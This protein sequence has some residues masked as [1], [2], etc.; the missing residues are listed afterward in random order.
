MATKIKSKFKIGVALLCTLMML[1][2]IIPTDI[3]GGWEVDA[4][5][6][7]I[8][9]NKSKYSND[10]GWGDA[11]GIR[12]YAEFSDETHI[13]PAGTDMSVVTGYTD[14]IYSYT[15]TSQPSNFTLIYIDGS[16]GGSDKNY[17]EG[18]Q[19]EGWPK[20]GQKWRQTQPVS[21]SA[22]DNNKCYYINGHS[23]E[24]KTLTSD[25]NFTPPT[26]SIAGST[27]GFVDM[28][29]SL[30]SM[31]Y[32]F[33]GNSKTETEK[34]NYTPGSVITVGDDYADYTTIN[35]Y[36]GN[37]LVK[38]IDLTSTADES[39]TTYRSDSTN[40]L[41]YGATVKK[42]DNSVL[43]SYWGAPRP[44]E[45]TITNLDLYFSKTAFPEGATLT[46]TTPLA[47][48]GDIASVARGNARW[49]VNV[50]SGKSNDITSVDNG[51]YIYNFYWDNPSSENNLLVVNDLIATVSG[52]Y[53]QAEAYE[54]YFDA[55]LSKLSYNGD[56]SIKSNSSMPRSGETIYAY[57]YKDD[58]NKYENGKFLKLEKAEYSNGINTWK[59]VY[60]LTLPETFDPAQYPHIIF[61][62]STSTSG[63]SKDAEWPNSSN[64]LSAQTV[65]LQLPAK[66]SPNNCFYADTSDQAI[67]NN[68][69]RNGYWGPVYTVRDAESGKSTDVVP[70]AESAFNKASGT[71]YVNSTFY[72]YYSDYELN[73][74]DRINYDDVGNN[75]PVN[76]RRYSTFRQFAQALS[77]Y[78]EKN[79]KDGKDTLKKNA[80]YTGHF[81][82]NAIDDSNKNYGAPFSDIAGALSLYGWGT[83]YNKTFQSNNNS[84]QSIDDVSSTVGAFT[85]SGKKYRYATQNILASDLSEDSRLPYM[86]GTTDK[87]SGDE[88]YV[89][90]PYFNKAFIEGENCKNTVLG[91]IY[92]NVAFPFTKVDRDDNGVYY[93]SFDSAATTVHMQKNDKTV[94]ST[95]QY[96]YYLSQ[97]SQKT[98]TDRQGKTTEASRSSE[99]TESDTTAANGDRGDDW[100]KNVDASGHVTNADGVSNVYGFFPLNNQ[101]AS[102]NANNYNYGFGTKLEFDF[103]LT[104]D[105]NVVGIDKNERT[106]TTN[107]PITFNFSGDDDVWV[108]ID[109][110][111]VLDIGGDHGRTSG[112]INFSSTQA[113][114]YSYSFKNDNNSF[115]VT[116]NKIP[117][118]SVFVSEVKN[119]ANNPTGGYSNIP[120]NESDPKITSPTV[121]SLLS[122]LGTTKEKFF[123]G[124][125]KLT[126]FYMERG[127]WESNLKL[128]FNFPDSDTLEI[129]KKVDTTNL[130]PLFNGFFDDQSIFNYTVKNLATHYG[131][132][133]AIGGVHTYDDVIFA[134]NF[135][136]T[137]SAS[138][139][140]NTFEKVDY[141]GR[142]NVAHYWAKDDN[143]SGSTWQ[144]YTQKRLGTFTIDNGKE[145]ADYMD[146]MSAL[147]FDVYSGYDLTEKNM[148]IKLTD[149]NGYTLSGYITTEDTKHNKNNWNTVTV[150][151]STLS[152]DG[153]FS[154]QNL[155]SISFAYDYQ[156]DIWLD[157][158]VFTS[159]T[160]V[161][162]SGVGF[163]TNQADIP[164]YRSATSGNL[165]LVKGAVYSSNQKEGNQLVQD[166]GVV[167]LENGEVV[168]FN[169]Q[170]RRGSYVS[171]Q[172]N[173]TEKQNKLFT[174]TWTMYEDGVAVTSYT[175]GSTVINPDARAV[176]NPNQSGSGFDDGRI[177]VYTPEN[178]NT[179]YTQSEKP[180][181]EPAIV[182]RSYSN[183]DDDYVGSQLKL[184]NTN[185]INLG[186]ISF[187]K[188]KSDN[189]TENLTGKYSF[190]V[191]FRNIGGVGLKKAGQETVTSELYTLS[192]GDT[193]TITGIPVG[194]QYTIYEI[195]PDDGSY[196]E[197]VK[198]G[199]TDL[200]GDIFETTVSYD[201][202]KNG[203]ID[204]TESANKHKA[205]AYPALIEAANDYA[206]T[207]ANVKKA[208]IS[209]NMKKTWFVP[210]GTTVS[211]T[212]YFSLVRRAA[213]STSEADWTPVATY[214]K[215]SLTSYDFK[216][217][218]TEWTKEFTNLDEYT[219]DNQ[220][221]YVYKIVEYSYDSESK[222]YT[223]LEDGDKFNTFNTSYTV[224]YGNENTNGINTDKGTLNVTNTYTPPSP[225][226][227]PET[228][229]N[230][231]PFNYVLFGSIAVT[232]AGGALLIYRRK[233]KYAY[234]R[235]QVRGGD[236]R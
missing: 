176:V 202:D 33:S 134:D 186:S 106:T 190:V 188:A 70:V 170:F 109:G 63:D 18:T 5:G 51:T 146:V 105:G 54:I 230:G 15:F 148:Y 136:G 44:A 64:S 84:T 163:Q 210:E 220:T 58:N 60:K 74:N 179:G 67:Y 231:Q 35:F 101:R 215:F 165:E 78:Y 79:E 157:N 19:W 193:K 149:S 73:G 34:T 228:G 16:Y 30:T 21:L 20:S 77:D 94:T 201:E 194:T 218:A 217:G 137:L 162:L 23:S 85:K 168:K 143:G 169:N 72:D 177:E 83:G 223:K 127:Q 141:A 122:A 104:K 102:T 112:C 108:F 123:A 55:T 208:V 172:E 174:P 183:P 224:T 119:S 199:N 4:A 25:S 38:S 189:S 26:K 2:S 131:A 29:G 69:T 234:H 209:L 59:D 161:D 236:K 204:E 222:E 66:D 121:T 195:D 99:N 68:K 100:S 145:L 76:Q 14:T 205:H 91:E 159:T 36:N 110:K 37:T 52:S 45:T 213:N 62:S 184:V 117:A 111:L 229:R 164:D 152:K 232:L 158:F 9:F 114:D 95:K 7:T 57:I 71:K 103:T 160:L 216:D 212:A 156:T 129:A 150:N 61:I 128:Q 142:T 28:M 130:N 133:E 196:L 206:Y 43:R 181:D 144:T 87:N 31:T 86:Y 12:V 182:L 3:I 155:Q 198:S 154:I 227:M 185:T 118:L 225:I 125:H 24:S 203:V 32:T 88:T 171:V 140:N 80:M 219:S 153:D 167:T 10:G 200:T 126:F 135:S 147:K 124:E 93:W 138:S 98:I 75:T 214:D 116:H 187:T 180:E 207:F 226:I 41:Y 1:I 178:A 81:Q 132:K 166:D 233:L 113:Y 107:V 27:V 139:A 22:S 82:P 192:V 151:L 97:T 197:S 42:S 6:F 90:F 47:L 40:I 175:D 115:T 11:T 56:A 211:E 89:L 13:G 39:G 235:A 53:T 49:K 96:D 191:V 173:L 221:K 17:Q 120:A 8:Y 48:N 65:D 50:A 92:E 46:A